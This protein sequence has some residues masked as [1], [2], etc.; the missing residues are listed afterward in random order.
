MISKAAFPRLTPEN[1][2]A[3][4]PASIDYNCIA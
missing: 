4:S 1:H 2:R 3:T